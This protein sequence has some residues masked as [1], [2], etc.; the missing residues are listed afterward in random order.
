MDKLQFTFTVLSTTDEPKTLVLCVTSI[1]TPDGRTFELPPNYLDSAFHEELRKTSAFAKVKKSISKKGQYRKVWI[2]LTKELKN[3]YLNETNNLQFKDV[4]LEEKEETES[5]IVN[6]SNQS[7]IQVLE[8]LLEKRQEKTEEK[9]VG[10]IA[11]EFTIEKFNGKNSNAGLWM[12]SFE[13]ECERFDVTK[14][15]KRIELLKSFMEKGATDWYSCTLLKL[16]VKA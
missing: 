9:H 1:A 3:V 8:K 12:T 7:L 11:K 2:D 6:G 16:T 14:D 13:T 10:K 15:D 5:N 4:Y